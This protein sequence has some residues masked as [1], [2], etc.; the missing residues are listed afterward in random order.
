MKLTAQ[1]KLLPTSEQAETLKRTLEAANAA[2]NTISDYAWENRVFNGYALHRALYHALRTETE[3]SAQMVVRCLGK[4]SDAYKTDKH[5]QRT[6]K[7]HGSIPYDNRI[8]AYRQQTETVSIWVLGGR[9]TIPYQCGEGQRELLKHQRGESDLAYLRGQWYLLATCEID[10]PTPEQTDTFLGV[11]LGLANIAVDSE[12]EVHRASHINNVR[13]RHRRLRRK[14]QK[15]QTDSARRRLKKL[16]GKEA[17]FAK[18][19]NHCISK[20]IVAKAKDTGRGIALE[21]LGGIRDRITALRPQR[22]TLH[23]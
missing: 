13:H 20:R 22:V 15:K 4:V 23:N 8:L 5:A 1:V 6:F 17:R 16:S 19:T 11:D 9:Q 2:C 10:E 14:L 7:P 18:D 12:G 3:L 21:D